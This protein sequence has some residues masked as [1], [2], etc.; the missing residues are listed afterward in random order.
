MS[1]YGGTKVQSTNS[2][3]YFVFVILSLFASAGLRF[4]MFLF[5]ASEAINCIYYIVVILGAVMIAL[6]S[7]RNKSYANAFIF[8][9]DFHLNIF[10][11]VAC[12]GFFADFVYQCVEIFLSVDDGD[13][14]NP[15]R[16]IPLCLICFFSLISCFYFY[17]VGL[18][19]GDKNYDF[20]ELK[21]MHLAPIFWSGVKILSQMQYAINPLKDIGSMLEYILLIFAVCFF[22]CF[23]SEIEND[24]GA[25]PSTVFFAREFSYF[26]MLYFIDGIVML[27]SK[28]SSLTDKNVVFSVCALF[29]C[30]FAFFFEK[31]IVFRSNLER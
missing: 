15:I 6:N 29:I 24:K 4:S 10:S 1:D 23:A 13:Y 11:Y 7:F 21:I 31:N 20:R 27:F 14:K 22:Y 26:S 5:N 9:N 18:S 25:K 30:S 28:S 19:F 8:K 16:F 2:K 3:I 17:T 12:I